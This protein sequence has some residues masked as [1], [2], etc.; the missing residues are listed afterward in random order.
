[1]RSR[2][3]SIRTL[4]DVH[5]VPSVVRIQGYMDRTAALRAVGL[6]EKDV[7]SSS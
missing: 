6:S 3:S 7:E 5:P 4:E 2:S 1:M